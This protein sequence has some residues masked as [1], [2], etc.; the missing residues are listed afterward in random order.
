MTKLPRN[1][2]VPT[3]GLLLGL[4]FGYCCSS[5]P[6]KNDVLKPKTP[7]I[8]L[9]PQPQAT[10]TSTLH[11]PEHLSADEGMREV[12]R[13][14]PKNVPLQIACARA[15]GRKAPADAIAFSRSLP[16]PQRETIAKNVCLG[17][18]ETDLTAAWSL[19]SQEFTTGDPREFS[20]TARELLTSSVYPL[21]FNYMEQTGTN[22]PITESVAFIKAAKKSSIDSELDKLSQYPDSKTI[23]DRFV[24]SVSI[25]TSDLTS[26]TALGDAIISSN[27]DFEKQKRLISIVAYNLPAGDR[28]SPMYSW[29]STQ[30]PELRNAAFEIFAI[31]NSS[32]NIP[33]AIKYINEITPSERRNVLAAGILASGN[34]LTAQHAEKLLDSISWPAEDPRRNALLQNLLGN[35]PKHDIAG[36]TQLIVNSQNLSVETKQS[37]LRRIGRKP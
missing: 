14:Y 34:S 4:G 30:T 6:T 22:A 1:A 11:S 24:Y 26:M 20:Q 5:S 28:A 23:L 18:A 9:D 16:S 32:E 17:W 10:A 13:R 25:V 19:W 33:S 15:W 21:T 27:L 37:L 12:L 7:I 36:A 31:K 35:W 8:S 2:T 29:L 3:F